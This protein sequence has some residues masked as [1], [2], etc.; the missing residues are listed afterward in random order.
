MCNRT[1]KGKKVPNNL[2]FIAACNPYRKRTE[3]KII[4]H[5]LIYQKFKNRD[6]VYN[7]VPLPHSIINFVFDFGN[8]CEKDEKRYIG[9]MVKQVKINDPT[10]EKYAI[11]MIS[12]CQTYIRKQNGISSVSLRDARRFVTF[13]NWFYKSIPESEP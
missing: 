7:L 6:L 9:S 2:V 12:F 8:L 11:E 13:Y 3:V 1:M 10:F 4:N 5:G